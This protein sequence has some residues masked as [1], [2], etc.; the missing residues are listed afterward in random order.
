MATRPV[1]PYATKHRRLSQAGLALLHTAGTRPPH[2]YNRQPR[3]RT[4]CL[5]N[6]FNMI[7]AKH[8]FHYQGMA[9]S[10]ACVTQR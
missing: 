2:T 5:L 1:Y 4:M 9:P 7:F 3:H 10:M 6:S 8:S